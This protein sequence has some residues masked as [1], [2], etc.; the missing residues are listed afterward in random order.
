MTGVLVVGGSGYIGRSLVSALATTR[1]VYG[2]TRTPQPGQ[3]AC[4]LLIPCTWGDCPWDKVNTVIL[5][6]GNSNIAWCEAHQQAAFQLNVQATL[7]FIEYALEKNKHVI[8]FSSSQ[9]FSH[10]EPAIT[11]NVLP[12]P[13]NVYGRCKRHVETVLQDRFP[14]VSIIRVT[15]VIGK[16]F[17][18]FD[19]WL[20]AVR[21]HKV[22][23]AFGDYYCAP[24]SLRF[25]GERMT[26]IIDR[27][28][29]GVYQFSGREDLSYFALAQRLLARFQFGTEY[30]RAISAREKGLVPQRFGSL[31]TVSM[32]E[33][34]LESEDIDSVLVDYLGEAV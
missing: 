16:S 18:L 20:N 12:D 32:I 14:Q 4:D 34:A 11:V 7:Q 23:E 10:A 5:L 19:G 31:A 1:G 25:L 3:I 15:K 27:S 28:S 30:I 8:W 26:H 24:V 29:G 17:G 13:K 6:A 9:V 21:Q 33:P 22:I 2:T